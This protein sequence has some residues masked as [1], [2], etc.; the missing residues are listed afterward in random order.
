M[1][2]PLIVGPAAS[3]TSEGVRPFAGASGDRLRRLLPE[4]HAN[5]ALE[6]LFD[7]ENL[8]RGFPG[9]R[10][11]GK[12][13]NFNK[14][15]AR[16]GL[17]RLIREQTI[18]PDRVVIAMGNNAART[19]CAANLVPHDWFHLELVRAPS[20]KIRLRDGAAPENWAL[21]A[22]AFWLLTFPHPSGINLWWNDP[23]NVATAQ[24]VME[25]L[26]HRDVDSL[27]A[28]VWCATCKDRRQWKSFL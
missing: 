12:G 27:L 4:S 2:K 25:A 17:V 16:R 10:S 8:I 14:E 18:R 15:A 26:V 20:L 7:L 22:G 28:G 9:K 23:A 3:A 19:I 5:S 6:D 11:S 1:T 21:R 24:S 13:D